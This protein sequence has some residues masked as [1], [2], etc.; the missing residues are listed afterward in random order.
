MVNPVSRIL[1]KSS[2][3]STKIYSFFKDSIFSLKKTALLM[4][5]FLCFI[6]VA[7]CAEPEVFKLPSGQTVVL[8]QIPNSKLVC[9]DT[10]VKTGSINENDSNSGVA[11]FLEHLFFKGSSKY[12]AGDFERILD[13]KGAVYN[14]ATSKDFTHFYITIKKQDLNLALD[15]QS[16]MLLHPSIPQEEMDRERNVVIEEIN[17][18]KDNPNSI[19]FQNMNSILFKQHPYKREVIGSAKVIST[20]SRDEVMDFYNTWYTPSNMTTVIAGDFDKNEALTL[21]GQYFEQDK[22][23]NVCSKYSKEP[24]LTQIETKIQKGKYSTA[25]LQMAFKGTEFKNTKDAYA[26][27]LLSVILGQGNTSYLYKALKENKNLVTYVDAGHYSLRDSSVF[28]ISSGLNSQNYSIV[29]N[30]IIHQI[31][32]IRSKGVSAEELQRAKNILERS[33][34]YGNESVEDIANSIGYNMV[35]GG[36]DISYYKDYICEVKK[37]SEKDILR[38][39]QQYLDP[40]KMA[41][42]LLLPEKDKTGQVQDDFKPMH[43]AS[44]STGLLTFNYKPEDSCACDSLFSKSTTKGGAQLIVEKN[45]TADIVAVEVFIKGGEFLVHKPG[46]CD[47]LAKTLT[48]GT[49]TQSASQIAELLENN[50][51]IISPASNPDCFQ[52]SMKSTKEDFDR[53]F[54]V[55]CDILNN[56]NFPEKE[57]AKAKKDLLDSIKFQQDIPQNVAIDMLKS[58]MYPNSPY[59]YSMRDIKKSIPTIT[60]ADV[61]NYYY[62]YFA[63]QNMVVSVSGDVDVRQIQDKFDTFVSRTGKP[64]AMQTF[65]TPFK[66]LEL[67]SKLMTK[68]RT[69]S[70]WVMLGYRV[71]SIGNE[72]DYATLKVINSIL[73]GGMSSRLFVDMRERKGLAYEVGCSY[74][75]FYG[76]SYFVFYIGTNPKNISL[77][78]KEFK[79]EIN[80]LLTQPVNEKE[81]ELAKQRLVGYIALSQETNAQRASQRARYEIY[82]KGYN[83]SDKYEKLIESVTGDDIMKT[84]NKYFKQ[85]FV[86]SIVEPIED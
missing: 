31:S 10:W 34:I 26:L 49:K 28:Y 82:Q 75:S 70:A 48:R 73:S 5:C 3:L 68:K 58:K 76:N 17:R 81:L 56:A 18:S 41:V 1:V 51:I 50:G 54:G 14:A 71:P 9:V 36:D 22:K 40:N 35:L 43:I 42:S 52:I 32:C 20:I 85:P 30:E 2:M 24:D 15:L 55:L 13:G 86:T 72:K 29:E 27:D 46:V 53:A 63:P 4:M 19:V 57:V 83:F 62:S 66:P 8:K 67:S 23:K 44:K 60:R 21:V 33:Y 25:Y 64:V 47:V 37:I 16:N 38:V 59:G 6:Q 84:A 7:F 39:A 69:Q 77:V 12:A 11:H 80:H 61:A 65:R 79:N 74:P 45:D 78:Q